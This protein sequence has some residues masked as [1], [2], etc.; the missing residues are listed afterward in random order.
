MARGLCFDAIDWMSEEKFN[1]R[2]N[3]SAKYEERDPFTGKLTKIGVREEVGRT[4]ELQARLRGNF[5]V[6][7]LKRDVMPQ[8]DL[9]YY[10]LI[11]VNET[12]AVKAALKAESLLGIDPEQLDNPDFEVLG[13]IAV[14][15]HQMGVAMAPQVADYVEMVLDGGED[16]LVL[17]GWHIDVLD[18]LQARLTRF[19]IVRI[20][21]SVPP[22]R[23]QKMV[24]E[25]QTNPSIRVVLGN[26]QSVGTGTDGLQNVACH[27][28]F[29]E[30]SWVPGENEQCV[31]RLDRGGQKRKVQADFFV[32]PNS[33][34]ERILASALRKRQNTHAALDQQA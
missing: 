3:P 11:R 18:Y 2:F 16:K 24:D 33:L 6:R 28:L 8:L 10:D 19:G 15:R 13:H 12:G 17:Y 5:M 21:G 31:D 27:C 32:A 20:D 34:S 29:A 30:S 4:N 1:Q 26:M 14:V 7:R 25:F 22:A 23:R 9:P